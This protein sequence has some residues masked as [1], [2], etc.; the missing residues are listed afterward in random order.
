MR[1]LLY[2]REFVISIALE[3]LLSFLSAHPSFPQSLYHSVLRP[4]WV[5]AV[6]HFQKTMLRILLGFL[7]AFDINCIPT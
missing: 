1:Q 5:R 7:V 4:G 2:L 6:V 3:V